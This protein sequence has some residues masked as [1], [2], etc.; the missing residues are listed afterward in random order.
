MSGG[1]VANASSAGSC[2]LGGHAAQLA[3]LQEVPSRSDDADYRRR[4]DLMYALEFENN[5]HAD[6]LPLPIHYARASLTMTVAK[7]TIPPADH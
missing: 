1:H 2:P 6:T 4:F 5:H 7:S 3:A